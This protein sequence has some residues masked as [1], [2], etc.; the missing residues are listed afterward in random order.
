MLPASALP[1]VTTNLLALLLLA[2]AAGAQTAQ[3]MK[4]E[5]AVKGDTLITLRAFNFFTPERVTLGASWD[6]SPSLTL[7]VDAGR[8]VLG[9]WQSVVIVDPNRENR[10]RRV[11]LT[12]IPG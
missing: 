5:S 1:R 10:T 2:D 3:E 12:F 9:T 11:R 7:P 8:P 4:S 6:V